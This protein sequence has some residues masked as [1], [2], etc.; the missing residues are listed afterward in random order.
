MATII[1]N[2]TKK[3]FTDGLPDNLSKLLAELNVNEATVVAEID[4]QVIT[5][6][7]FAATGLRPGQQIE[8]VRFVPGG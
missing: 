6:E 1:I 7:N 3:E 2:G 4:G 5:R 8:L